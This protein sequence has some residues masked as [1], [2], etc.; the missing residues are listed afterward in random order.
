[1]GKIQWTCGTAQKL[2]AHPELL[3]KSPLQHWLLP[4]PTFSHQAMLG[5]SGASE[6]LITGSLMTNCSPTGQKVVLFLFRSSYISGFK[7][8]FKRTQLTQ[9]VDLYIEFYK[10]KISS[11]VFSLF[12]W[13]ICKYKITKICWKRNTLNSKSISSK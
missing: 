3:Q 8:V 9:K 13:S 4:L 2:L 10:R 5:S 1:M 12:I 7:P 11:S 6:S